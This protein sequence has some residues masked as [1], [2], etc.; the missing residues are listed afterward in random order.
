M[1]WIEGKS[2]NP[3]GRPPGIGRRTKLVNKYVAD[4][5]DVWLRKGH[6]SLEKL[7]DNDPGGFC[8]LI[9]MMVPKEELAKAINHS[10]EITLKT[11]QWLERMTNETNETNETRY[12]AGAL[13]PIQNSPQLITH[14]CTDADIDS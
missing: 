6:A 11:P 14:D 9:S 7:A 10:I 13:Q 8:R 12:D 4:C 3:N 1:P 2:G 5:Y